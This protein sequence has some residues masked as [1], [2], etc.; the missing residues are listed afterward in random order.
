MITDEQL[1]R[2]PK[3]AQREI[4]VLR[5][6]LADAERKIRS[7]GDEDGPIVINPY[8]PE[9]H[10]HLP[11]STIIE[12]RTGTGS[13]D[14]VRVGYDTLPRGG[15]DI[16]RITVNAGNQLAVHP[17]AANHVAITHGR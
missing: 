1:L 15:V 14:R 2:L 9:R 5:E 8:S 10:I 16:S 17:L 13:L 3:Y 4:T 12:M 7:I 6:N 11:S